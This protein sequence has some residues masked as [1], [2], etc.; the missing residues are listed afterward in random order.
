MI[1]NNAQWYDLNSI[2][3]ELPSYLMTFGHH[4]LWIV[5]RR[6]KVLQYGVNENKMTP[7]TMWICTALIIQQI[8][9]AL[10]NHLQLNSPTFSLWIEIALTFAC[11][12]CKILMCCSIGWIY[13]EVLNERSAWLSLIKRTGNNG[14]CI[15]HDFVHGTLTL[16]FE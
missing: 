13:L 3:Y 4:C 5:W 16:A 9:T 6:H 8:C 12:E 2:R 10:N 7:T 15:K 1:Q 11:L 14:L